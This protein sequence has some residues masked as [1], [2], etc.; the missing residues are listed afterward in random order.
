[1]ILLLESIKHLLLVISSLF[2]LALL[3]F[4]CLFL[5]NFLFFLTISLALAHIN[6]LLYG[7]DLLH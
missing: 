5:R 4:N 1:M 3:N 6:K 7:G 2:T